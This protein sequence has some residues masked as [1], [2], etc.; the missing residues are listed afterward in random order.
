MSMPNSAV[1]W[2]IVWCSGGSWPDPYSLLFGFFQG[3]RQSF[4]FPAVPVIGAFIV[5]SAG[6]EALDVDAEQR[7]KLEDRLVLQ[8]RMIAK[9]NVPLSREL[10]WVMA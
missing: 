5:F 3:D 10:G 6:A 1:S 2:K 4:L 8:L 7:R 9:G